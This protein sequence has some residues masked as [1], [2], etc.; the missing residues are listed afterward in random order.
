[1]SKQ[2]TVPNEEQQGSPEVDLIRRIDRCQK[3]ISG[4]PNNEVVQILFED[5][6]ESKK[7]IDENWHLV[8][9]TDK[10]KELRVTKLAIHTLLNMVENYEHDLQKAQEQLHLLRNSK[11]YV[12]KDYDNEGVE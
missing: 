2:K 5:L 12:N 10:L 9:D 3:V 1:M 8:T 7:R 4:I 11:H 6:G